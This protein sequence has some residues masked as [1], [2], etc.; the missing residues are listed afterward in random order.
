M[1]E[2]LGEVVGNWFL[3]VEFVNDGHELCVEGFDSF[4]DRLAVRPSYLLTSLQPGMSVNDEQF[5]HIRTV[6]DYPSLEEE[7]FVE[8]RLP[9]AFE[10]GAV[11]ESGAVDHA[12]LDGDGTCFEVRDE[13][14]GVVHDGR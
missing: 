10:E 9:F 6:Y 11:K 7:Y 14:L 12:E 3:R 8:D 1:E 5:A 4:G 2:D 13:R